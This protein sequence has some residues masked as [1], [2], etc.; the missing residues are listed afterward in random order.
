M[1]SRSS[2]CRSPT[3]AADWSNSG[4]C[5]DAL[6]RE[7][8]VAARGRGARLK[9]RPIQV[10]ATPSLDT[11]LLATALPYDQRERRNFYL[12]MWEAFMLRTQGVRHA[13]SAVLDLCYVV[14]G[15]VDGCG[16]SGY[17]HGISRRG[18][19]RGRGRRPRNQSRRWGAGSRS[20]PYP[21]EQSQAA[22]RDARE[23]LQGVWPEAVLRKAEGRSAPN[24]FAVS[25][26]AGIAPFEV[27][28]P[29]KDQRLPNLFGFVL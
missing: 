7:L 11:A 22:S 12:T 5:Y 4:W 15:R 19:H 6:K 21:G 13:G 27:E 20:S 9:G 18:A 16:N 10:S 2:A 25:S 24:T 23:D 17:G 29:D 3:S 28:L 14:C 1:S 26:P 8:F